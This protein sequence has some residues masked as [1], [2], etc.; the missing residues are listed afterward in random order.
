MKRI[1]P[2]AYYSLREAVKYTPLKTR[3]TLARYINRYQG[4]DWSIGKIWIKKREIGK[5]RTSVRYI[6]SG[7]WIKEFNKRYKSGSLTEHAIFTPD[8]LRYTLKDIMSYCNKNEITT[9]K[10]FIEKK[11]NDEQKNIPP[12]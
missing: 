10:Q 12:A 3:E 9:V 1:D 5:Q 6:I 11:Q 4:A 7:E 8:E 2:A